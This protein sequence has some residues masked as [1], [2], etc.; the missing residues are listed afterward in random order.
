MKIFKDILTIIILT[1]IITVTLGGNSEKILSNNLL[2][3][4]LNITRQNP[5]KVGVLLY[6]ADDAYI[7]EVRQ[8]LEDIQKENE[9]KVEF[10]FFDA[11][12]DQ[13][14]QDKSLDELLKQGVDLLMVNLVD[15]TAAQTVINKIKPNNVP[16]ILFN[17]EPATT[18]AIKSYGRS[19][20]VGTD[21]AEAGILQGE[22]LIEAWNNNKKYIDTDRNNVMQYI[23]LKGE[24]DNLE[25]IARTKYSIS[26]VNDY[27][28]KTEE[29]A[30]RVC[31]WDKQRAKDTTEA[32]LLN[33]GNKI[34]VIVANNDSMAIGAVE[35]LQQQGYNK[36]DK[37]RTIPVV[38]VDALPEA[39][40]LIKKG[41]MTGSVIQ[42]ARAMAEAM[43]A[44]GLNLVD[45]KN[46]LEGT[47]YEFDST[48]VSIR[49]P[50]AGYIDNIEHTTINK[51]QK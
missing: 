22:I 37:T 42:D 49:I 7:S 31:D 48:G 4:S 25:A 51:E 13:S 10:T 44:V 20:F 36:G 12:G 14:I 39:R 33:Y 32:L 8:S 29:I 43:Y 27:G 24:R 35:A 5:V 34:E 6:K 40:E 28:I 18:D 16:V 23:M 45:A 38:G 2:S 30:L 50:Y 9:G 21:A 41:F 3:N 11:K 15:T 46:P 26:T 47:K 17:R 19:L 1:I